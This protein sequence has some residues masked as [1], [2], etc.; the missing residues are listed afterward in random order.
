VSLHDVIIH[1]MARRS[2]QLALDLRSSPGWGGWR[3]GAGRKRAANA[4]LPH[5]SRGEIDARHP[6]HVTFKMRRGIGSLRS[7]RFVRE[8]E[9]SFAAIKARDRCR[10]AHYSIQRDHVHLLME[11][12]NAA[13]LAR[14]LKAVG[15][16]IAR[17]VNRV[18]A[19]VGSV[20]VDRAHV[21]VLRTPTE[22]RRALA[23]VLLNA[24]RHAAKAGRILP[25]LGAVD[26]ASSGRW[27][28]GWREGDSRSDDAPVVAMPR[29]WL[30]RIGWR[31]VGLIS[32][33]EV[34]GV[35]G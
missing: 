1:C 33:L 27:F 14:G 35:R 6:V 20:L 23:Y 18:F 30:L 15:A 9:R 26:P 34:P 3:A 32:R 10:V 28:D 2:K 19:R 22:V 29:S 17:A 11:A 13:E 8:I 25:R 4:R 24:R 21:R 16:R 12:E 7:R 5:R 31:R